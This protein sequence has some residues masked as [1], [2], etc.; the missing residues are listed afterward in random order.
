MS[1]DLKDITQ[2]DFNL[3]EST[4]ISVIKSAYPNLDMRKGTVLRELL[5]KVAAELWSLNTK[6]TTDLSNT[7]SLSQLEA[8]PEGNE[9][10]VDRLLSNFLVVRKQGSY[11]SGQLIVKV[12]YSRTYTITTSMVFTTLS[13]LAYSPELEY[14]VESNPQ[15]TGALTLYTH[16]SGTY[17]YFMLPVKANLTGIVYDVPQGTS[18]SMSS[19]FSGFVTAEAYYD[20]SGGSISETASQVL[21]RLPAA[22]ATRSL[23][24]RYS[25]SSRLREQFTAIHSVS[26]V[27]MGNAEQL[28]DKHYV[29]SIGGRGDVYAKT[30]MALPIVTLRKTATKVSEGVYQFSLV[31][32]EVP[33]YYLIRAITNIDSVTNAGLEFG[34]L[35]VLGSYAFTD[36][37][38]AD[39][40]GCRHD[41][42]VS[43]G[44]VETAYTRYQ[45]S[46]VFVNA[47]LQSDTT[48]FKVEIYVAPF[49]KDIQDY[50]DD[51]EVGNLMADLV[52]RCPIACVVSAKMTVYQ[53]PNAAPVASD[54]MVTTVVDYINNTTFG[55]ILSKSQIVSALSDKYQISRIDLSDSVYGMSLGGVMRAADGTYITISGSELDI[56]SIQR[57]TVL[58]TPNTVVFTAN[59][60]DIFITV[61]KE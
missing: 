59:R 14:T 29:F 35:S 7:Y 22:I 61:V 49:I 4:L 51:S 17:Y 8:A 20:F 52:V 32:D 37:R 43:A 5:T 38:S 47:N 3:A 39:L 53:P 21:G 45:I 24:S 19:A 6:R 60:K 46:D 25:I 41:F 36:V 40:S 10:A 1:Y 28:R 26:A 18:F 54:D 27:G 33:G 57:P 58:V 15:T 42:D 56:A 11:A 48:E 50:M 34:T 16:E 30:F 31:R 9:E 13:G 2:D 44:Y 55:H 23:E 12:Q